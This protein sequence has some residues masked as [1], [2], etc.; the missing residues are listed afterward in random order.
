MSTCTGACF[1]TRFPTR[2]M[3]SPFRTSRARWRRSSGRSS[4]GDRPTIA[5]TTIATI[6]RSRPRRGE[7]SS[8]SSVS[9]CRVSAVTTVS[10]FQVRPI[11]TGVTKVE[12]RVPQHGSLQPRRRAVV[13]EPQHWRLRG[14]SP[15]RGR[16]QVQGTDAAEHRRHRTLHARRQHRDARRGARSLRGRRP[17]HRRGRPSRRSGHDNPNKSPIVKGFPLTAE[18]KA[19][20][21]AF[22]NAL[23]DNDLLKDT[24]FA[25][26]WTAQHEEAR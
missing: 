6:P 21:I 3:R 4:P 18:Q 17:Y 8:C 9:R 2:P 22:L 16:W 26:P 5:I 23:T 7:A 20:V 15:S 24:R 10:I 11:L 1:Q 25:N 13:P 12:A 19:D 14:Q